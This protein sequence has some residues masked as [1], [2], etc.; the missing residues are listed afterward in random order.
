M[1]L[2]NYGLDFVIWIFCPPLL[3]RVP[4]Y[5]TS[6]PKYVKG[7]VISIQFSIYVC[8]GMTEPFSEAVRN[9][10]HSTT[11]RRSRNNT[12]PTDS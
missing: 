12:W 9:S 6:I 5:S 11:I 7:N 1:D 8:T 4:F 3:R 2:D 10:N